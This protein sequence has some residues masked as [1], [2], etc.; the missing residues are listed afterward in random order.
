MF[1]TLHYLH[2]AAV[3]VDIW[4]MSKSFG[5]MWLATSQ[6]ATALV[7]TWQPYCCTTT[8]LNASFTKLYTKIVILHTYV[9][10]SYSV[11]SVGWTHDNDTDVAL[12]W[13][14]GSRGIEM[15]SVLLLFNKDSKASVYN[16]LIRVNHRSF[17]TDTVSQP[18]PQVS[19]YIP[20]S[21]T[22]VIQL[23]SGWLSLAITCWFNQL[24]SLR[25][26]FFG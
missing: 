18:S 25:F 9:H 15:T 23:I 2:W 21:C 14:L 7:I 22:Y 1:N 16:W 6:C 24:E 13:S 4:E 12:E 8:T 5:E 10:Y 26:N 17:S 11:P 20:M 19:S 3:S